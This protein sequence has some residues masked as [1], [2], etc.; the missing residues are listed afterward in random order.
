M[1]ATPIERALEIWSDARPARDDWYAAHCTGHDDRSASLSFR[2]GDA[3]GVILKCHAGCS[4]ADILRGA[5]IT[6]RD[7][8][9]HNGYRPKFKIRPKLELIDLAADKLIPWQFLFKE[10]VEDEY[11]WKGS[12]VVRITYYDAAGNVHSKI[13]L[14]LGLSGKESCWDKDSPGTLV[15]YG[16]HRLSMAR[17][18][19]YLLIGEGESDAWT[20]WL[21][22]IPFLGVPGASNTKCLDGRALADIPRVYIIQEPDAAGQ[23]FYPKVHSQLRS[24]GYTG[25]LFAIP[26]KK[27]TG[28]KDPNALHKALRGQGFTEALQQALAAAIPAGDDEQHDSDLPEIILGGQLRETVDDSIDVLKRTQQ[29]EQTIFVQSGRLV[30]VARDE[31]GR[32]VIVAFGEAALREALS[33]AANF[34]RL[35]KK[36]EDYE[37]VSASPPKEAVESILHALPQSWPFPALEAIVETP[38]IRPDGSILDVPGYDAA[39]MLYYAPPD[40]MTACKVPHMP[41]QADVA[42]ALAFIWDVIGEFPYEAQA[43]KANALAALLTPIIRPALKGHVPLALIDAPKPGSGKGLLAEVIAIGA[44]GTNAALLSAPGSDEEWDKRIISLLMRGTTMIVVDNIAGKLQS[45]SLDLVL[46]SYTYR[47]RI[48][49]LSKMVDF[50]NRATWIAVGN[51]LKVG[52]DLARRCYRIRLDPKM[53]RPWTRKGFKHSDLA[54]WVTE[55]RSKLIAALLTIARAWFVAGCPLCEATPAL[56]TFTHWASTIGGILHAAGVPGFLSNLDTLYNE[57]DEDSA[58][59]ENFLNALRASFGDEWKTVKQI[60]EAIHANEGEND[61]ANALPD[62]L[63]LALKEKPSSFHVKLG[64]AF[65]KREKTRY[66]NDNLCLEKN[67]DTHLKQKEWHVA[68]GAFSTTRNDE[69]ASQADLQD[70]AGGAGSNSSLRVDEIFDFSNDP[71][72]ESQNGLENYPHHPQDDDKLASEAA[73]GMRVVVDGLPAT[74]SHLKVHPEFS[75]RGNVLYQDEYLPREEYL[76][77]LEAELTNDSPEAYQR[78]LAELEKQARAYGI[79][80]AA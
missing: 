43:D 74:L 20:C 79:G 69:A 9:A 66:G 18:A 45:A 55:N 21:H 54:S 7:L 73:S 38:V 10:G 50:P 42:Q 32:P 16:L 11:A 71:V 77:R 70:F 15:P 35:R 25:E 39:T 13:R 4:R 5:G 30:R 61:L 6:E 72:Y 58:Q 68:G 78:A 53:S 27:L 46:T 28:Q 64:K 52:G 60:I 65:G 26:F 8:S 49:G 34:Y 75:R 37:A 2:E 23:N 41:T 63:Q 1:T 40:G 31:K 36:G 44:T 33:R 22:S 62:E 3:G 48:L 12:K 59:W 76:A 19:G 29:N 56:G 24:T 51:N 17:E 67:P 47:G 80:G 14:R 57:A